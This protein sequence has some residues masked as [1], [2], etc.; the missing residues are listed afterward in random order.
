MLRGADVASRQGGLQSEIWRVGTGKGD[1]CGCCSIKAVKQA[2]E[3]NI[4]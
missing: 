1:F 3:S 4:N 2:G